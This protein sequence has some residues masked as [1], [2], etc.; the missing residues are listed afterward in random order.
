MPNALPSRRPPTAPRRGRREFVA[1]LAASV[2]GAIVP[3]TAA[4]ASEGKPMA[5]TS[6]KPRRPG[7]VSADDLVTLFTGDLAGWQQASL[8]KPGPQREPVP[9]PAVRGEY[10]KGAQTARVS[11]STGVVP[12]QA[13]AGAP[14]FTRQAGA[15][16]HP[17]STVTVSLANGVQITASS[18]GADVADLEALLKAMDLTRAEAMQPAA[19]Q[20]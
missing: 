16:G 11:A 18:S 17:E 19:R 7:K 13:K 15:A 14:L 8:E 6:G 20:R 5:Q 2:C 12:A 4:Q 3:V 9:G 1:A 10:T